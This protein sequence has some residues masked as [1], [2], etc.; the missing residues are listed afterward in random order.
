ME[1][2]KKHPM[3]IVVVKSDDTELKWNFG[4]SRRLDSLFEAYKENLTDWK[5]IR[6]S[7]TNPEMLPVFTTWSVR[8][9]KV[10][11]PDYPGHSFE[12]LLPNGKW[13]GCISMNKEDALTCIQNS[14]EENQCADI[15]QFT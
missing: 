13:V 6:V 2:S 12:I 7:I 11:D 15:T 10:P 1:E 4:D 9:S 8:E 5:E 3:T 14:W